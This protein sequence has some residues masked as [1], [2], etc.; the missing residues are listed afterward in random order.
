VVAPAPV[1]SA[2]QRRVW[3]AGREDE[4]GLHERAGGVAEGAVGA[5]GDDELRGLGGGGG[6][7]LDAGD[8]DGGGL[9]GAALELVA[10]DR[11]DAGVV[12]AGGR[13]QLEA[14]D[15][16]GGAGVDD[17]V[18]EAVVAGDLYVPGG[19]QRGA[20]E[21]D[22]GGVGAD[23][24]LGVGCSTNSGGGLV[25]VGAAGSGRGG[26]GGWPRRALLPCCSGTA[27]LL[28]WARRRALP[29]WTARRVDLLGVDGDLGLAGV[30][31]RRRRRGWRAASG[32]GLPARAAEVGAQR[33]GD[34]GGVL[35]LAGAAGLRARAAEDDDQALLAELE[36][37]LV[38]EGDLGGGGRV[39]VDA[40][41]A[42]Q[43][44]VAAAGVLRGGVGVDL[45]AQEAEDRVGAVGGVG[46]DAWRGVGVDGLR[47]AQHH[48]RLEVVRLGAEL[49]VGV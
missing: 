10:V 11:A 36:P 45:V 17:E 24:R 1:A 23:H 32:R 38:G 9:A 5:G 13:A 8:R 30:R 12:A 3:A 29:R 47:H 16:G 39:G 18:V 2:A 26:V 43:R 37:A 31:G 20:G 19:G 44:L 25:Q 21:A 48:A 35:G 33:A 28:R 42:A 34:E 41:A 27:T 7:G 15:L 4:R 6:D 14:R 22:A 46:A 40:V 49:V